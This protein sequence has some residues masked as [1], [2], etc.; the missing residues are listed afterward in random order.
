MTI[1][2]HGDRSTEEALGEVG[3]LR[4][5]AISLRLR[6]VYGWVQKEE[7]LLPGE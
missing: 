7:Q 3:G 2:V 1:A 5:Q 4:F 6:G